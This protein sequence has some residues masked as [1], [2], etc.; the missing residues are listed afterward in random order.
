MAGLTWKTMLKAADSNPEIKARTDMNSYRVPEEFYNLSKD[1][2]E[3]KNLIGSP[4]SQPKI[5]AMR[6]QLLDL[7]KRTKD[8]LAGA[9]AHRDQRE[10]TERAIQKLKDEYN[11]LHRK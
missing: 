7:M 10:L 3:R 4:E 11:K 9:F 5:V 8:P 2:F 6:Q 1:P